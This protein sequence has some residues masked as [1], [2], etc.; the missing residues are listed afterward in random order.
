MI[1]TITFS[2]IMPVYNAQKTLDR[3]IK[4][5][6]NQTFGDFEFIIINDGSCDMSYDIAINYSKIDSRI[7][8]ISQKNKGP[9]IARNNGISKSI[10]QYIAFIDADDYWDNDFLETIL[11]CSDSKKAD[12]IFIDAVAE[13]P[14]GK[15]ANYLN[16]KQNENM[17]KEKMICNQ[18]TGRLPWG[19]FKVIRKDLLKNTN[20]LF[21][22]FSV[23]E[24]AILSFEVLRNANN[25]KFADKVI[26]H[27]VQNSNGQHTKGNIDPWHPMV[28][29]MKKHLKSIGEYERY[30]STLNS[31][32][33]KSFSI[34]AY[35]CT[36]NKSMIT[37]IKMMIKLHREY[38]ADFDLNSINKECLDTTSY[39]I[40]I[41][42]SFKA[43]LVIYF[44]A[45]FRRKTQSKLRG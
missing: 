2:I 15:V 41:L 21:E 26:Y 20:M 23:G 36:L 34:S 44:L 9:G 40:Y 10:G 17:S 13:Y 3:A 31:L 11:R 30:K 19:M 43:Y 39:F 45:K 16:L 6:L 27:Y 22:E 42:S 32:A 18:M 1:D 5:V 29:A 38:L 25:I 28:L 8:V 12:I 37:S 35:R 33:L 14:N 7:K 4:S 24:E